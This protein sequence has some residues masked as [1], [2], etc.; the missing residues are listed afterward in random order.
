MHYRQRD[1][2]IVVGELCVLQPGVVFVTGVQSRD[3]AWYQTLTAPLSE[4]QKK[5]LQEIF[6]LTEQRKNEAESKKIEGQGGY[7]FDIT[8]PVPTA[9]NFG[10]TPGDN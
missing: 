6:T 7:K 3:A 5:Q 1:A 9:F 8:A 2:N 10:A 4:D